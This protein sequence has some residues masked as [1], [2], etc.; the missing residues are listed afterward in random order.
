MKLCLTIA[1]IILSLAIN[2]QNATLAPGQKAPDF[3]L[4]NVDNKLISLKNYPSAKGFILVFTC[5]TC[6]YSQAYEKRIN[7]LNDKYA[8]Q[9][10][11]VIAINPNNAQAS[12][13]DSFGKMKEHARS[14]KFT[15]PYLYDKEQSVTT[16]YGARN[17]PHVFL[18]NKTAEGNIV[19][20]TGAIDND[21]PNSSPEKKLF[22][23]DA[24]TAL[25]KNEKPAR[26]VTKAIGCTVKW[27]RS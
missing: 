20:Y 18:V 25:L 27:K 10:F 5:N 12:P 22:V 19:E 15:F 6:P 7:D 11:P 16:M 3:E 1:L 23:E 2:A 8:P 21:T 17:T 4:M 9:G 13:G 24:L 26:T 14:A